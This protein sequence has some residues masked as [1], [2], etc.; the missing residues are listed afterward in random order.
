MLEAVKA[1][2]TEHGYLFEQAQPT[3]DRSCPHLL[4]NSY[5]PYDLPE[6]D[7]GLAF[8][9]VVGD[10]VIYEDDDERVACD[11]VA[12]FIEFFSALMNHGWMEMCL[13]NHPGVRPAP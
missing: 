8:V 13:R 6:D 10:K 2:L 9:W 4:V 3:V 11:S 1:A 5:A 12:A 7:D